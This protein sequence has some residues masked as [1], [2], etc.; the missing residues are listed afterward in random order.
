MKRG[1]TGVSLSTVFV[2]YDNIYLSLKRKSEEAARRFAKDAPVWLAELASGKLITPTNGP[3][4][5]TTRRIVM[6]RCYGNPVPRRN[7]ADNS[8]DMNSFPFVRHHFLRS[9]FEVVDCPP[10]TAQLKNSSDIRM[11]MDI[12]DYLNHDTYF[13]EFIILSGD[14]DFTPLLHRLRAHAR[15]TVI[16]AN[17]YTA[18]PYTAISDGE[19]RESDLIALLLEGRA[20]SQTE[21]NEALPAARAL[22]GQPLPSPSEI[23]GIRREIV[24]EVIEAVRSAGQPVPLEALADRAVRNLGH[25]RTV[26]MAWGGTGSF[27]E[28]LLKALPEEIRLSEQPPYFVYDASRQIAQ[29]PAAA[30]PEPARQQI[31]EEPR[32][33]LPPA[34]SFT[35]DPLLEP[36]TGGRPAPRPEARPDPRQDLARHELARHELPRNDL[37]PA[38]PRELAAEYAPARQAPAPAPAP[39]LAMGLAPA[40]QSL[41]PA[42]AAAPPTQAAQPGL[43]QMPMPAIPGTDRRAFAAPQAPTAPAP[44]PSAQQAPPAPRQPAAPANAPASA[45]PPQAQAPAATAQ[46]SPIDGATAIQRSIARIH[47]AC[48]APPLSPPEYRS[49]FDI[50]AEEITRNGLS[51]AQTLV[52]I[53]DRATQSGIE[54]RRDDIRFVL[55]VISET[56]PW[57]EQGASAKLFA[58]RFRNFVVA[59]CRSQGLSLSAEELDLIDAWFAGAPAQQ[60]APQRQ[61]AQP[62]APQPQPQP[63]PAAQEPAPDRWWNA[64][65]QPAQG[66]GNPDEIG[67]DEFP[68]IVRRNVR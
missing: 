29:Q 40:A 18:A 52:N 6:S 35:L 7:S 25:E 13:D 19:V 43:R 3:A 62:A 27:R 36:R 51:G 21:G 33:A 59:R 12:R 20:I 54:V 37:Q 45:P 32:A 61:P 10:L 55:D 58:G 66:F 26:G 47:D 63:Q 39:A 68:R 17:D 41:Q 65:T 8:T 60:R 9:G 31:A 64:T 53:A 46:R 48:Q 11:V 67:G 28:L 30:K 5:E 57:F 44:A 15:R 24:K 22:P 16:F 34:P 49:L 38:Q 23:D 2:D 50:I 14:A 42:A 56:D 1:N 4:L